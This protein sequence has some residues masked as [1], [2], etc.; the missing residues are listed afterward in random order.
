MKIKSIFEKI[1]H[2][3]D[4]RLDNTYQTRTTLI[5]DGACHV[6]VEAGMNLSLSLSNIN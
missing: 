2:S 1:Q 4:R 3:L 5:C 6:W